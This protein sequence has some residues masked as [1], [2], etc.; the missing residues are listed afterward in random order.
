M[1][2]QVFSSVLLDVL[3][4]DMDIEDLWKQSEWH[5]FSNPSWNESIFLSRQNIWSLISEKFSD[6]FDFLPNF[7]SVWRGTT[8]GLFIFNFLCLHWSSQPKTSLQLT[9]ITSISLQL[10]E[11]CQSFESEYIVFYWLYC[12]IGNIPNLLIELKWNI[13]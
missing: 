9:L 8:S 13:Q 10:R 2:F 6:C 5:V 1:S 11:M 3:H 7:R 12:Y 4:Q